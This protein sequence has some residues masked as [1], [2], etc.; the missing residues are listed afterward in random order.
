MRTSASF[1]SRRKQGRTDVEN[2]WTF[3]QGFA[4]HTDGLPYP[5]MLAILRDCR[6]QRSRNSTMQDRPIRYIRV[7]DYST[8]SNAS[9]RRGHRFGPSPFECGR[10]H[11]RRRR[12]ADEKTDESSPG[13][14]RPIASMTLDESDCAEIKRNQTSSSS[15]AATR[16]LQRRA[17]QRRECRCV[18]EMH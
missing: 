6:S 1:S 4:S 17:R 10:F 16:H 2:C 11:R 15:S 5:R 18:S 14:A 12:A 8:A 9:D 13:R 3:L 7:H